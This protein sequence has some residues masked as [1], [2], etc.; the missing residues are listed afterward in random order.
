MGVGARPRPPNVPERGL[1]G[2][3]RSSGAASSRLSGRKPR[4]PA[5]QLLNWNLLSKSVFFYDR[6]I[7]NDKKTEEESPVFT[8]VKMYT[9]DGSNEAIV[10][11]TL[12]G[13]SPLPECNDVP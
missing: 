3:L 1:G 12:Y 4:I 10:V 7:I 8:I 9:Y 13:V 2:E 5:L 6:A 11:F